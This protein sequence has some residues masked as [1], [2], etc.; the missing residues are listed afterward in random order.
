MREKTDA[1]E[2]LQTLIRCPSVTPDEGGALDCL[3]GVL[4]PQGFSCSRL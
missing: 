1:T 2:L 4:E 3:Q